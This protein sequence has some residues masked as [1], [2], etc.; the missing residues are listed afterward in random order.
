M[1][2]PSIALAFA[3]YFRVSTFGATSGFSTRIKLKGKWTRYR[4]TAR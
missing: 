2:K 3:H 1:P 4:W